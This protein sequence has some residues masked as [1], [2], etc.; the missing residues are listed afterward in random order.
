MLN[1]RSAF[2]PSFLYKEKHFTFHFYLIFTS[3][4]QRQLRSLGGTSS[5]ALPDP[6]W[7]LWAL[8]LQIKTKY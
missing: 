1:A 8:A 3:S 7:L 5:P 2:L 4:K 6:E